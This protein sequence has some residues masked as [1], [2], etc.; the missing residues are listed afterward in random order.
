VIV[1]CI[2]MFFWHFIG[3][4]LVG[5]C[6]AQEN[7]T[8]LFFEGFE[9]L[10]EGRN[11]EAAEFF[12]TGLSIEPGNAMA[13]YFL[14]EAYLALGQR[15]QA[16]YQYRQSVMLDG[17]SEVADRARNRLLELSG[18]VASAPSAAAD[19]VSGSRGKELK[20]CA[21]CPTVVVL[22]P[23]RFLMGSP[24]TEVG[25]YGDEGPV[26]QIAIT[27]PLGVAK[28][29]ITFDEWNACVR[30]RACVAVRDEGWGQGRRP[31]INVKFEDAVTY[32]TWLTR[33]TGKAYRL[34]SEAEWEYAARAGSDTSRDWRDDV[35]SACRFANVYD[36]GALAKHK[37]AK[38][39][40][41]CNDGN[42]V[43]A[44]VGS[45][46][47]N[48]FGLHDM[49]GNVWEWVEDCWNDTYK[50]APRDGSA[51]RVGDCSRR[52]NRGASWYETP[53]IVRFA[54]RSWRRATD[55]GTN[56]LGFRVARAID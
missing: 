49:L 4:V 29:E 44:T 33:K 30:D 10:K 17:G 3:M 52:V 13:R 56:A 23:G 19:A 43:T 50:D 21:E 42:A 39:H 11:R 31:V 16:E 9:L 34:L 20:D 54:T 26:R 32:T 37:V 35:D 25:R 2:S 15:A 5:A 47:P 7:A 45:Y 55:A 12:V 1:R 41:K 51:W 8:R 38:D 18:N 53:R 28:Y 27:R 24:N 40:F 48:A 14:G 6:L 36:Q 46:K 22:P